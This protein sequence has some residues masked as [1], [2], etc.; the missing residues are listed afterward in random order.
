MELIKDIMTSGEHALDW[1]TLG[2]GLAFTLAIGLYYFL[3]NRSH[4]LLSYIPNIWTSL[5][6][7]GTFISI[8]YALGDVNWNA[9][10]V[11]NIGELVKRIVP[12]FETSIIGIIGAIIT[13]IV[14]KIVFAQE[15]AE[16]EKINAEKIKEDITPEQTLYHILKG[17]KTTNSTLNG[18]TTKIT[19]G[20]LDEVNK[21]LSEKLVQISDSHS[22]ELTR[23]FGEEKDTLAELSNAVI[24]SIDKM[25][26]G[27]VE[28][29][30]SYKTD[31][32]NAIKGIG[33]QFSTEM[34]TLS[35]LFSESIT[36][37][38]DETVTSVGNMV[39]SVKTSAEDLAAQFTTSITTVKDSTAEDISA[40]QEEVTN[41]V[42]S[43]ATQFTT[44][45][46]DIKTK[47]VAAIEA[48]MD[49]QS[50]SLVNKLTETTDTLINKINDLKA[51]LVTASISTH[52][53]ILDGVAAQAKE[54]VDSFND[55]IGKQTTAL[56][57][58]TSDY[59][60][61]IGELAKEFGD[62]TEATQSILNDLL[63]QMKTN[64][65]D[66]V[67]KIKAVMSSLVQDGA[68]SLKSGI[69]TNVKT[70]DG[71]TTNL[72]KTLTP[73]VGAIGSSYK[74]YDMTFK[75]AEK[76]LKKLEDAETKLSEVLS[77]FDT[78]STEVQEIYDKLQKI[79][80]ANRA[81]N[82][83]INELHRAFETAGKPLPKKC[84]NCGAEVENPM[85][86][87]CGKCGHDLY[88]EVPKNKK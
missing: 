33:D 9:S 11:V 69:D 12:A 8:V 64:A 27:S 17:V 45:I 62:N 23:I 79:G 74:E 20:I 68:E 36:S 50:K 76:I 26:K 48:S 83:R 59:V 88:Q 25:T 84:P 73:L 28:A 47:T 40:Y 30:Q 80:E 3:K 22:A 31:N 54:A 87:F 52:K 29:L 53:S 49:T 44:S 13:S 21:V 67:S 63:N 72:S 82:Y 60:K 86:Q 58:L 39:T 35:Q 2:L 55:G 16:Y 6:I 19:E 46:G 15:E 51:E 65:G 41:S 1:Y 85:A 71:L 4:S 57:K 66:D 81:L 5:G 10:G 34:L 78:S 77:S 70:L 38:K 42:Q 18:I 14:I 24:A 32:L 43:L 7:L 37:I 75:A 56:E 61:R